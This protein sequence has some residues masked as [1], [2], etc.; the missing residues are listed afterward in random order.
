MKVLRF[1]GTFPV[2]DGVGSI[3][4]AIFRLAVRLK[5]A[6]HEMKTNDLQQIDG[7]Y[8]GCTYEF[9]IKDV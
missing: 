4:E 7:E 9:E 1:E 2:E 8:K 5:Q 6:S 3:Q